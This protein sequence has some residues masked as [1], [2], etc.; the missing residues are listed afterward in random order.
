MK[1]HYQQTTVDGHAL[2]VTCAAM[3]RLEAKT[4]LKLGRA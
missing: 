2:K 4:I 3:R 1:Y